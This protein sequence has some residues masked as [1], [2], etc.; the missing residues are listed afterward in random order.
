MIIIIILTLP[1]RLHHKYEV[2][3]GDLDPHIQVGP[4]RS[5]FFQWGEH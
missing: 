4:I 3:H 2:Q 5:Y 1:A